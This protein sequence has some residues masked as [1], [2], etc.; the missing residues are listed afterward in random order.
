MKE[1]HKHEKG[2]VDAIGRSYKINIQKAC[3]LVEVTQEIGTNI[4]VV[5]FMESLCLSWKI[6]AVMKINWVYILLPAIHQLIRTPHLIMNGWPKHG[7]FQ[8]LGWGL[9]HHLKSFRGDSKGWI[10]MVRRPTLM[11]TRFG[12]RSLLRRHTTRDSFSYESIKTLPQC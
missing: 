12:T 2:K 6:G 5:S 1:R 4:G 10:L 8:K 3:K 11:V 9:R 7:Q